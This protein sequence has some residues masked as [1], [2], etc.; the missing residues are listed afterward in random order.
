MHA[1]E[2]LREADRLMTVCNACRYC[3]GLCAVFPAMEMRR[4][5]SAGD[6]TYL[7]NLC[8]QCGACF[9]DC[10]YSPPHQF[11]VNVP[12]ALARLRNDSYA[13][14]AW[15]RF[16]AGAFERNGLKIASLCAASV[17]VFVAGFV[18][19]IDPAALFSPQAGDFY[20]LMPHQ[21]MI[22]LFG[23]AALYALVAFLAG[24]AACWRDF[25]AGQSRAGLLALPRALADVFTLRYLGGG[26]GGCTSETDRP[27][28]RRRLFHHFTFY[29]FLLCFAATSVATL[30]HY[31][32]GWPAPYP[33]VSLPVMLGIL[34]G[35][36]LLIGPA[37]LFVLS[38]QRDPKLTDRPRRGMDVTF[39]VMLF[40]TS[41]TGLLLLALRDTAAMGLLL[42]IHLGVVLALFLSLPYGKFVHALYRLLAL[43]QYAGERRRGTFVE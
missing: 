42:S 32:Y 23:A 34:G 25:H 9:A 41:L 10:Q 28:T 22:A 31:E 5:F 37:G 19:F 4:T 24:M 35:I 12:A 15:P 20:K 11:D 14:Y 21:A 8:H 16:L 6:L 39:I 27:S 7:A 36:G 1:T 17:A 3:E 2:A 40:L 26:G 43:V 29:G 30:Y 38:Q 33:V 13:R 18:A